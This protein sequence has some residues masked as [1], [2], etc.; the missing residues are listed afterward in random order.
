[1]S[2][3]VYAGFSRTA[4][5]SLNGCFFLEWGYPRAGLHHVKMGHL[6]KN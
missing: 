5:K 2:E 4:S 3:T 6:L 1:M